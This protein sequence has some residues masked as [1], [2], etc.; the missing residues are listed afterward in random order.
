MEL[1]FWISVGTLE[2][3]MFVLQVNFDGIVDEEVDATNDEKVGDEFELWHVISNNVAFWH[4]KT[5]TSL[6][7]L[8]LSLET[9]NGVQSV[10]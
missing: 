6:C 9:P 3:W 4:V 7:S 10:A 2:V 8:F 1:C 5:R